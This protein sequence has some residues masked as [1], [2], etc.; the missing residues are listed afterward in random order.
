MANNTR[1]TLKNVRLS[2]PDLF[3]RATFEGVETKYGATLI[4]SKEDKK[5][6][7]EIKEAIQALLSE[8]KATL[9]ADKICMK[10][11]D[12]A[13]TDY[14]RGHYTINASNNTRPVVVNRDRS[15]ITDDD[16]IIYG[17][18]YV[19][20]II[21]FWYLSRPTNRRIC[22]N[23]HAVQFVKD[24]ERFGGVSVSASEFDDISGDEVDD[25]YDDVPF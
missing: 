24:G 1:I 17:G 21:D 4:I 10:D 14:N 13:V 12:L 25:V 2:F 9:P 20:A 23:L 15:P 7:A 3:K 5:A 22:C 16:D 18:C 19:N 11:G 8:N 6:V